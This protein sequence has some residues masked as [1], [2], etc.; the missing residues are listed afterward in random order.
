M[1]TVETLCAEDVA[2]YKRHAYVAD[3]PGGIKVVDCSNPRKPSIVK[4]IPTTYAYRIEVKDDFLYLCDGPD[5]VKGFSCED[6]ANPALIWNFDSEWS[7]GMTVIGNYLYV[8]DYLS[9]VK[10]IDISVPWQARIVVPSGYDDLRVRDL[11]SDGKILVMSDPWSGIC[12]AAVEVPPGPVRTWVNRQIHENF[13]DVTYHNGYAYIVKDH[14]SSE[15]QVY[16]IKDHSSVLKV[17]SIKPA[18]FINGLSAYKNNLL[19]SCGEEGLKAFDIRSP[20][21]MKQIWS[22]PTDG[23][24]LNAAIHEKYL[25][26][27]E[28]NK[29]AIYR[30]KL[31]KGAGE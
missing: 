21:K 2:I 14:Q 1:G 23:F 8:A 20:S 11:C 18:M 29:L 15:L 10:I 30:I 27:C 16:E 5:G 25:Y 3:G 19:V 7:C 4:T 26:V 6:P 28:M 12:A 22:I 13:G 24:V 17:S 9:G 31:F